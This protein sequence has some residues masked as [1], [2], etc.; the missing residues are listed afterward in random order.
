[1]C[2][3]YSHCAFYN[4]HYS[5]YNVLK[6][7]MHAN[8][9]VNVVFIKVQCTYFEHFVMCIICLLIKS[10]YLFFTGPC[11]VFSKSGVMLFF[12]L[13]EVRG[14]RIYFKSNL[15]VNCDPSVHGYAATHR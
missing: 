9:D 8:L 1:M 13:I 2:M 10:V 5:D 11:K 7:E 6:N 4:T 3:T 12:L 15:S 14:V